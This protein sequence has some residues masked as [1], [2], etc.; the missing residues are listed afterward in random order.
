MAW[1]DRPAVYR[2]GARC[3]HFGPVLDS[4]LRRCLDRWTYLPLCVCVWAIAVFPTMLLVTYLK[5]VCSSRTRSSP[6]CSRIADGTKGSVSS[7]I[8]TPYILALLRQVALEPW[9]L[10][11]HWSRFPRIE[12]WSVARGGML[13]SPTLGLCVLGPRLVSYG[14]LTTT[15]VCDGCDVFVSLASGP[16]WEWPY[17]GLLLASRVGLHRS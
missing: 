2:P 4:D 3:R 11:I 9:A 6:H 1:L 17:L 5:V 7:W 14:V 13:P 10:S 12:P 15:Y 8:P 16:T